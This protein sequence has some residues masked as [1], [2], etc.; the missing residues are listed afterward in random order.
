MNYLLVKHAHMTCVALSGAGFVLRGLWMWRGSP[1]LRHPLTRVLP[2]LVDTALLGSALWLAWASAQYPF[3]QGWL[4]AKVLGL[5]VYIALGTLAL[6]GG[7]PAGQR[8]AAW[9][10]ALLVYAYLL[11]VALSHHPAGMFKGL[12]A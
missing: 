4:S 10:A 11:S 6:K 8:R 12:L 3:V 5:L 9:L 1:L 7:R 2:H